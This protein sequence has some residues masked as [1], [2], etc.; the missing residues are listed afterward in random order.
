MMT[1]ASGLVDKGRIL[2]IGGSSTFN[3][4]QEDSQC[5]RLSGTREPSALPPSENMDNFDMLIRLMCRSVRMETTHSQ[6]YSNSV[7]ANKLASN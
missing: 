7:T 6:K 2:S 3:V 5:D 4:W 1:G